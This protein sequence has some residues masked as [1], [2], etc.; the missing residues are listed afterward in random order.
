M[1]TIEK[2]VVNGITSFRVKVRRK[3]FPTETA[4][5]ERITDAKDWAS[6]IEGRMREGRHFSTHLSKKHTLSDAIERYI[7]TVLPRKPKCIKDQTRHLRRWQKEIGA[8]C[9]ANIDSAVIANARD[10]LVRENLNQNKETTDN[11]KSD[12]FR[13][14]STVNR[15]VATLSH[16][17]TIAIKEWGWVNDNPTSKFSKFKEPRGRLRILSDKEKNALLEACKQSENQVLYLIVVLCLSTG[18]RRNEI[19]GLEKQ[20]IDFKRKAIVLEDTKNGEQRVLF[21]RDLAWK[22]LSE[23]LSLV[24][25][26]ETLLVFPSPNNPEKPIDI[27]TAWET[28]LKRAK[29]KNF[30]FHDLRHT[31]ASYLAMNGATLRDLAEILGHKTL[32]M[33]KRYAHLTESHTAKVVEAMNKKIFSTKESSKKKVG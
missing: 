2:R 32:S 21:I 15:Y 13:S 3:G 12:K 14:L 29:I 30:R 31:A 25:A 4:T 18:A 5:F 17:Y 19:V 1:A 20:E 27:Q 10:A 9:L 26:Q 33:V 28:A 16:L 7:E 6:M 11:T 22:L 8:Y 24:E 23:H